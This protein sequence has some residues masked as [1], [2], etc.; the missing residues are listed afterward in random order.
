M[1]FS[2][3]ST[4]DIPKIAPDVRKPPPI[5]ISN[6][7]TN[8]TTNWYT[9]E[10][11]RA[12][13]RRPPP[14]FVPSSNFNTA[15]PV[16]TNVTTT[17]TTTTTTNGNGTVTVVMVTNTQAVIQGVLPSFHNAVTN[18]SGI[19][20]SIAGGQPWKT[21]DFHPNGNVAYGRLSR[22]LTVD[23]ITFTANYE[24]WFHPNGTVSRGYVSSYTRIAGVWYKAH[25]YLRFH[26]N[27]QVAEGT[28]LDNNIRIQGKG[29]LR[30]GDMVRYSR[31]G[32]FISV[33]RGPRT[34]NVGWVDP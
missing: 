22:N 12:S 1:L 27:G 28:L 31:D 7:T 10:I 16:V 26:D 21:T 29:N 34:G 15:N 18:S 24:V 17:T 20:A 32:T 4:F 5:V 33:N 14:P 30:N 25:S 23:G 11:I 3:V 8:Y 9:N 6:W 19:V 2:C 13:F